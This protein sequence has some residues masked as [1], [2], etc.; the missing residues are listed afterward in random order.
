MICFETLIPALM[1]YHVETISCLRRE[2][3]EWSFQRRDITWHDMTWH[4]MREGAMVYDRGWN[5]KTIDL[6]RMR[7][8]IYAFSSEGWIHAVLLIVH[9]SVIYRDRSKFIC[10]WPVVHHHHDS[11][12]ESCSL[13]PRFSTAY[14]RSRNE[15]E[16]KSGWLNFLSLF[17][18]NEILFL[19]FFFSKFFPPW[20]STVLSLYLTNEKKK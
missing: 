6:S 17:S 11:S 12:L 20:D 4:D 9:F 10:H 7:V 1:T 15:S 8:I 14:I 18:W 2:T 19:S 16:R 13:N 5:N 3:N